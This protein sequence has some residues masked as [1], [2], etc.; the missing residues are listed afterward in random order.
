MK[1]FKNLLTLMQRHSDRGRV[2]SITRSEISAR[3]RAQHP[4][5][6]VSAEM[7][8]DWSLSQEDFITLEE[9]RETFTFNGSKW[10]II[11]L[12]LRLHV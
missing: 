3:S 10:N 4:G 1:P 9:I 7:G 12:K 8:M 2:R 6:R 11:L 5:P